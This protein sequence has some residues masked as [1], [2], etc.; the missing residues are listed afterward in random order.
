MSQNREAFMEGKTIYDWG[1]APPLAPSIKRVN[2][3]SWVAAS[4]AT[5]MLLAF[6]AL[7]ILWRPLFGEAQPPGTLV[8]HVGYWTKGLVH[9]LFR[10]AF[11]DESRFYASVLRNWDHSQHNQLIWR[12]AVAVWMFLMPWVFLAAPFLRP[13]DGLIHLRGSTRLVG[14]EAVDHLNLILKKRVERRPDHEIAPGVPYPADLWTRHVLVVGGTGSG[15]STVIKPLIEKIAKSGEQMLLFDPKSEFTENF[16]SPEIIAPWDSRS[17][18]WDIARDMRNPLDMR[19]FA[20]TMIRESQD[21]MWSNASRQLLV[22]LMIYLQATRGYE[23]GWMELADMVAQ[24]QA[25]LLAIMKTWHPEAVRSVEKASVTTS[26]I[27]IN[28]AS[29]CSSIFDLAE[30]WG[31]VPRDRRISFVE[32]SQGKSKFPQVILQGHGAYA[33]L[34]K[35]YAEGIVGIF[36][37]MVNSVEMRDN[38]NNKIWFIADEFAQLGKIPVRPLFEVGRSRGVRCV[39]A[40]QDFAQLEEIY[41][42][43]MVKA[44]IGM[45]GTMLVGQIM[46]GETAEQLCKAFGAREVER[47][48]MSASSGG[49]T[50]PNRSTTLSFNRDEVALY[51]PSELSSRLGMTPDGTGMTLLLFTGGQAF[52]L[53]WPMY[54][55][56]FS[57]NGHEPAPWTLGKAHLATAAKRDG[58]AARQGEEVDGSRSGDGRPTHDPNKTVEA[59]DKVEAFEAIAMTGDPDSDE[60]R[61]GRPEKRIT[62]D[63]F[64]ILRQDGESIGE[65]GAREADVLGENSTEHD[66]NQL[67]S[68]APSK[69]PLHTFVFSDLKAIEKPSFAL[70]ARVAD[71]DEAHGQANDGADIRGH[72]EGPLFESATDL[73]MHKAGLEALSSVLSLIGASSELN[74]SSTSPKQEVVPVI[75]APPSLPIREE[76]PAQPQPSRGTKR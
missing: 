24:P 68:G 49:G 42:A 29:F 3:L 66:P 40:C 46:Q 22:G 45:S 64:E 55:N 70:D 50:G 12:V 53:V 48:N 23:W 73:V 51:K 58:I 41:G 11:I 37:A 7:S 62:A 72:Q 26:G 32:W 15:K 14:K 43:P 19:R 54:A 61:G 34:T 9:L 76:K 5:G 47:A 30:A 36:S 60:P 6:V 18:A 10:P 27:L 59:V 25:Q 31:S 63:D 20:A 56:K 75:P 28:L 35:S 44:L 69:P 8:E 38:P 67:E 17:L 16:E 13:R 74:Q 33:D 1:Q 2:P 21:P 57:R 39:V 65:E 4:T 52:E 71:H